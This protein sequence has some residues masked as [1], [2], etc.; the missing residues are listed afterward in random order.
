MPTLPEGTIAATD[1]WK[2]FRADPTRQLLR[3]RVTRLGKQIKG[4]A[5]RD[6]RWALRDVNF[7]VRPGEMIG[8]VG[9]PGG[10]FA[11]MVV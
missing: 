10:S 8:L 5:K 2:R 1:I 7:E 6:W 9:P 11:K 4:E 3:D